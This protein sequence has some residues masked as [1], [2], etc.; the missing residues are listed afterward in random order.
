MV[1]ARAVVLQIGI[2]L[3]DQPADMLLGDTLLVS[4]RLQF[5]HQALGVDPT[6]SVLADVELPGVVAD[7]HRLA[8]EPVCIDRP[9]QRPLGGDAYRIGRQ[10]HKPSFQ[11]GTR[12]RTDRRAAACHNRIV[13][14]RA[15]AS[16][17]IKA[18][19]GFCPD[20]GS[21]LKVFVEPIQLLPG[22]LGRRLVVAGRRVVVEAVI[23]ALV[24][25][26]LVRHVRR[27]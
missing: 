14:A 10:V 26:T 7:H 27:R 8:E 6:E 24:D 25:M 17:K 11:L 13:L 16:G 23:G 18:T 21:A 20:S 2:E 3:P 1:S 15:G 4:E 22:F 12:G 19:P 5:V 9:P